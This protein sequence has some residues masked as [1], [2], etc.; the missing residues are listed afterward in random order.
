MVQSS[1]ETSVEN[2]VKY[3]DWGNTSQPMLTV[4]KGWYGPYFLNCEFRTWANGSVSGDFYQYNHGQVSDHREYD[5]GELAASSCYTGA[6]LPTSPTPTRETVTTFQ[7][8]TGP[9]SVAYGLTFGRPTSIV[10]SGNGTSAAE[11]DYIYDGAAVSSVSATQHDDVDYGVSFNNRGNPT[12]KTRKC[13]GCTSAVT[14]YIYDMTGQV[15]SMTDPCGNGTCSDMTGTSHKT[16]YSHAD[17]YSSGTP[18]GAT[19]AYLTNI[20]D[21]LGHSTSFAYS[22]GDG[23]LTSSTDANA[24]TTTYV[25]N[26][27]PTGCTFSDGLD[28]L[29]EIDYPD[30]GTTTY[31]YND[32]VFNSSTPSPSITTTE[33]ITSGVNKVSTFAFDGMGHQVGSILS[34]DPDGVTYTDTHYDGMGHVYTQ[35]NPYRLAASTTDGTTTNRYDALGR[36]TVITRSDQSDV[37]ITYSGNCSTTIDETEIARK[38]CSDALGRLVEVDEPGNGAQNGTVGWGTATIGTNTNGEQ[39]TFVAATQS[40]G[41]YTI[42]GNPPPSLCGN[43]PQ[44]TIQISVS[45]SLVGSAQYYTT[46][47]ASSVATALMSSIN[48]NNISSVTA[49]TA[50]G[51]TVTVKSKATGSSTNY[52]VSAQPPNPTGQCTTMAIY[53]PAN[54]MGGADAH[55]V[56]DAGSVS[57]TV[58]GVQS[59]ANYGQ[60][61]S[62]ATI[63]SALATA[64]NGNSSSP[65]TAS[66]NGGAVTLTAN[67]TGASSNYPLSTSVTWNT[68]SFSQPSFTPSAP[69]A[70]SGGSDSTLGTP[71][72]TLYGY[73][74]FNNLTCAVQKGTDTTAFTSCAASSATWRPRSFVY[75]SLS[76]LTSATNPESGTITYSYD[77]NGNLSSK[78]APKPGQTSTATVTTNYSYDVLNRVTKKSY[79]NLSTPTA[80]FAYDGNTLSGCTVAPPSISSPTNLLGR[81]SAMCAGLSASKWSYDSMGRPTTDA[82][83]NK[84][85]SSV[86]ETFNYIYNT[87][88]SLNFLFLRSGKYF[89]YTV[90]GAG[91]VTEMNDDAGNIY[92]YSASYTPSGSLVSGDV[93]P[94]LISNA[95]N[96]RQQPILLSDLL[97]GNPVFSLCYDFHLRAA[98]NNPPCNFSASTTGDNGNVFQVLNNVDSS[99]SAA[100]AYD[101]LNRISQAHTIT[102]TGPNC[103]GEVYTIDPWANLTNRAGVSGMG[104]CWTEGLSATATTKNQLS[105]ISVLYDAAGNVTNDGNGNIPTYDAENRISTDAGYTYSY[106]ADG[107]RMEKASGSSGTMY[108]P[109]PW[110]TLTETSLTGTINEDYAYLNGERIARVDR[111]SGAVHYYFSDQLGS[112]SVITDAS[113]NVQEQ[114]FYYPYGGMQ[115]SI[116]SDP[117]RYKFTGKE[118]DSESNLDEFGARYYTSTMGR[119]MTPDWA[120]K[121]T[122]VPYATFGNPQSLNLYSYV[123]NNPTTMGDPDGHDCPPCVA[124]ADL[125][126]FAQ[127]GAEVGAVAGPGGALAGF[128]LLLGVGVIAEGGGRPPVGY[129]PG[130]SLTDEHGNS[131][132][133]M[134]KQSGNASAQSAQSAQTGQSTPAQ[135]PDGGDGKDTTRAARR[136]AMRQEGIP[137]SQ[138][139]STQ[140]SPSTNAGRQYTYEVPKEGGGTQTKIVTNQLKDDNHGPHVEAG[141]PKANGQTDPSGR[142]RHANPK[143][144][145][146]VN[147]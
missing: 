110:G 122:S 72:V 126:T 145:V 38:T 64:V 100:F 2:Q 9:A 5:F 112:A 23:H 51:P 131:V 141:A 67:D 91:R 118:R 10:T 13:F 86:T 105:G 74:A 22:Y 46:S 47:T 102:T 121:P 52:A 30:T 83:T 138:Q 143:T 8:F 140:V 66:A 130:G 80:Q 24:K 25:Y 115:S 98:I 28:R 103:W 29:S 56:Y 123:E 65:V 53:G 137:T 88:G 109:G 111:P 119:F 70:L 58:N 146:D 69:S 93:G 77:A 84:G 40:T 42:Y 6:P 107:T 82:R 36:T 147:Q 15:I 43:G 108:W 73:D 26:T 48:N 101:S 19:N 106:D 61:D 31:C 78:V 79:V 35:S 96:S 62:T 92:M 55:T 18:P 97:N 11:T 32:A 14:T 99:R 4:N 59:V 132:F 87:D 39:S 89:Y 54:L 57:V 129:V 136:E 27:P 50:G 68:P 113:G 34:S 20:T 41:S 120:A 124:V 116:G 142:L 117:N 104:S 125:F 33:A 90:G 133:Q 71:L 16:T 135:P 7:S 21:T 144:K 60:N 85:S 44:G 75:D 1:G 76:R 114:Y 95:Y 37:E 49:T 17:N 94:T 134:S 127:E 81:R 3:Y 139:P 128:G 45:G 63:A 12:T